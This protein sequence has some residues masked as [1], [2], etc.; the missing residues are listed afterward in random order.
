MKGKEIAIPAAV[1]GILVSL[2]VY[3]VQSGHIA[4]PISFKPLTAQT[5]TGLLGWL[6]AVPPTKSPIF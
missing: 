6:F 1:I 5:F 4:N 2:D 3:L